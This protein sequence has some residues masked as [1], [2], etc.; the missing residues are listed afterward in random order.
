MQPTLRALPVNGL[1][2]ALWEWPG[3]GPPIVFAH[4]TGFHGRCWDAVIRRLPGRRAIAVEFRGHGRSDKPDPPYHWRDFGVD[5]AALAGSL[6][7]RGAIGVGHSM[8]GH[9]VAVAAALRPATFASLLLLDPVI[10]LQD[11]YGRPLRGDTSYISKRRNDWASPQE[12]ME[13]FRG[14]PPFARWQPEVLRD[15]C[16]FGLLPADGRF[17]LACPP[18]VEASIYAVCNHPDANPYDLL[19]RIE[20]PVTV[21]RGG[22]RW[23]LEKFDLMASPTAP[24]LAAH[25]RRG[26][27]VL[28]EGLSHYIPMESPDVVAKELA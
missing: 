11:Y 2:L 17:V 15:Y 10:F 26:R 14:R 8:G 23:D 27:D 25:F 12:M 24:D 18:A 22:I 9:A 20:Q 4:A 16:E 5:L 19:K 21:M 7:L 13:R 28:L 1:D 3:E 6:D